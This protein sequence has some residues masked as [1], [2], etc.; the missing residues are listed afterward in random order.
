MVL[1]TLTVVT[2]D[3]VFAALRKKG[4]EVEWLRTAPTPAE[5]KKSLKTASQLWVISTQGGYITDELLAVIRDFYNNGHGLYVWGDNDPL[6]WDANFIIGHLFSSHMSGDYMA[7]KILSIQAGPGMPGIV[8]NHLI[9]TGIVSFYEGVTI[10]HIQLTQYLMPLVYSSDGNIVTVYY[11]H[12]GRRA[13]IDGAFTRLWDQC[14]KDTAGTER[15]LVN[16]ACWL[17]NVERFGYDGD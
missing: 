10:A 14:W 4:F 9:S 15:Y 17:V 6:N 2:M 3:H 11:D 7:D 13:M 16:A 5:L 1:C 12:D 8:E